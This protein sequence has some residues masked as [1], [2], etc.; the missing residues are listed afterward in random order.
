MGIMSW[1][2]EKETGCLSSPM[3]INSYCLTLPSV[4]EWVVQ[5]LVFQEY[6]Q[7]LA[8]R[9]TGSVNKS[10]D[11]QS[12]RPVRAT[13]LETTLSVWTSTMISTPGTIVGRSELLRGK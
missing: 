13:L 11:C 5:D 4:R 3:A 10:V 1:V 6:T 12:T 8:E 9:T 7:E 2:S